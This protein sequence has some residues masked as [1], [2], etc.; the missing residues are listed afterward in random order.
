MAIRQHDLVLADGRFRVVLTDRHR[1]FAVLDATETALGPLRVA[2]EIDRRPELG[3]ATARDELPR[4]HVVA[5]APASH[6]LALASDRT[7]RLISRAAPTI[8]PSVFATLRDAVDHGSLQLNEHLRVLPE[9]KRAH[10]AAAARVVL[11]ARL[12]DVGAKRFI[13]RVVGSVRNGS[14]SAR[15]IGDALVVGGRFVDDALRT[16]SAAVGL[17]HDLAGALQRG[18]LRGAEALANDAR[19]KA[20]V[21]DAHVLDDY[22]SLFANDGAIS[23]RADED[24]IVE[25]TSPRFVQ[26]LSRALGTTTIT[27]FDVGDAV[28]I[29]SDAASGNVAGAVGDAGGAIGGS[30]AKGAAIGSAI[31]SVIPGVGTAIGGAVGAII[32][33]I[34]SLFGHHSGPL[35]YEHL[36]GGVGMKLVR[37]VADKIRSAP[38]WQAHFQAVYRHLPAGTANVKGLGDLVAHELFPHDEYGKDATTGHADGLAEW[39]AEQPDWE[40]LLHSQG[41]PPGDRH[42]L[43]ARVRAAMNRRDIARKAWDTLFHRSHPTKAPPAAPPRIRADLLP[44]WEPVAALPVS[45]GCA[46]DPKPVGES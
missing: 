30:L 13:A 26:P 8:G 15:Q 6:A 38:R 23:L 24:E 45:T 31:G 5:G 11:R 21:A 42:Q 43:E 37:N 7:F 36:F 16:S 44:T 27:G 41:V 2:L 9:T 32:G 19:A 4:A 35:D 28:N 33:G 1:L 10:V 29:A 20:I 22:V 18:D 34:G 14:R 46:C 17:F 3:A 12:G 39:F 40:R 25:M